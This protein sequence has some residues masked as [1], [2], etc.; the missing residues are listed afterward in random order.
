MTNTLNTPV[1]A[2]ER[3]CPVR[4]ERYAVI[5]ATAPLPGVTPGGAGVERVYRFLEPATVTLITERRRL[6]PPGLHGAPPGRPG[7]N[8]V[9]RADAAVTTPLPGKVTLRVEAGDAVLVRTPGG[10]GWRSLK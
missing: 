8:A 10:G 6:S 9:Q 4:I 7:H 1:E 3:A 2:L 5:E